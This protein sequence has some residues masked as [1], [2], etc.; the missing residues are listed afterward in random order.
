MYRRMGGT[1]SSRL[2]N[3]EGRESREERGY[4]RA[5]HDY[6]EDLKREVLLEAAKRIAAVQDAVLGFKGQWEKA[7]NGTYDDNSEVYDKWT[8]AVAA[9]SN[10]K[11]RRSFSFMVSKSP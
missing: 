2:F 3:K 9:L 11:D 10:V 8:Q 5:D 1:V 6:K 4:W 7:G